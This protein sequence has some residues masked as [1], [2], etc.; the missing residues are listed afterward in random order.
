MQLPV[1]IKRQRT[2]YYATQHALQQHQ[3]PRH[4]PYV[5]LY[6]CHLNAQESKTLID[7]SIRVL[8][9]QY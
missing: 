8:S 3:A 6:F 2:A 4:S 1:Q 5:D 9:K 7:K